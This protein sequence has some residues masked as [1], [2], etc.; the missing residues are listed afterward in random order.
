MKAKVLFTVLECMII[1]LSIISLASCS[2][3][4][5]EVTY[6]TDTNVNFETEDITLITSQEQ[7]NDYRDS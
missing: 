2:A 1:C 3:K 4:N 5:Y 7:L 6:L